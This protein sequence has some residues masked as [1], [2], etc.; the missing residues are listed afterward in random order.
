MK[1]NL[2]IKLIMVFFSCAF[3][4]GCIQPQPRYVNNICSIFIQ[5]PSWYWAAQETKRRWGV[6]IP[7]Q[8]AIIH[9][10]S[11]F[12]A[13]AK[14]PRTK[15][16]WVIP[17][18]RPSSSYGYT[19]AL[20]TTWKRYRAHRG[21]RGA[22]DE[23]SDASDF[24]GW[25]AHLSQQRA[26]ISKADAFHLYLAYHEGISGYRRGTYRRKPWLINVA[27]KVNRRALIFSRQLAACQAKLPRKP[28]YQIW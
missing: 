1:R 6:P 15:L 23:F 5:Y 25:Y 3:V 9:Q 7:V 22:R 10:E 20:E 11:R 14:P 13:D 12:T 16:L 21:G 24:I 8:M 27:K 26:G 18:K 2:R 19:Q 17:W 4:A 28:W